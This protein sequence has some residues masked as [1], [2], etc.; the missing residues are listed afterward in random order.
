[1][2]P[3]PSP[4]LPPPPRVSSEFM[5]LHRVSRVLKKCGQYQDLILLSRGHSNAFTYTDTQL[6]G[7]MA[8]PAGQPMFHASADVV[9]CL[10][11]H[12]NYT[13]VADSDTEVSPG[14]LF[15]LMQLAAQ[16][17]HRGIIQPAIKLI[18]GE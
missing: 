8:R 13:L 14:S 10:G 9:N 4:S 3:P 18:Q 11:R 16:H 6:Y 12:F 15:K 2:P 5:V 17:P 1:M 7:S